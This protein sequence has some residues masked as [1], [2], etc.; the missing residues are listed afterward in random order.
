MDIDNFMRD[1]RPVQRRVVQGLYLNAHRPSEN[2]AYEPAPK[3]EKIGNEFAEE[4]KEDLDR[5]LQKSFHRKREPR[6]I[7]LGMDDVDDDD[8]GASTST[9][10]SSSK[11]SEQRKLYARYKFNNQPFHA[12]LPIFRFKENIQRRVRESPV[13]IIKGETGCGKSTQVPQ[14][15]LDDAYNRKE[16]CNI[17]VTQPRRIAALSLAEQVARE[18][19]CDLSTLVGCQ[20]GLD[21]RVSEDTRLTY[22]TTGVLLQKLVQSKHMGMY[23]HIILDEIH[24]R[25]EEMEFLLIT[26]KRFMIHDP[27]STKIILMSATIDTEEFA[28]YFRLPLKKD[29]WVQAPS[30]DLEQEREFEVKQH[31]LEALEPLQHRIKIDYENPG[32]DQSMYQLACKVVEIFSK[33]EVDGGGSCMLVFLP[34]IHEIIQMQRMLEAERE[35]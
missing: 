12:R 23:T 6:T 33:P 5:K 2:L 27:F 17:V 15:I 16:Y 10:V 11:F 20:I 21:R 9:G 13:L 1:T 19:R 35:R 22:C 3:R 32:I 24:E 7:S 4:L 26:I 25:D 14:F 30:L 31:Y 29:G 28:N 34:G 18:R 8:D